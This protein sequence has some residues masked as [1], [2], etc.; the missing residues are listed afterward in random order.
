M[1]DPILVLNCGSLDAG[2]LLHLMETEKLGVDAE[3]MRAARAGEVI[4]RSWLF[5]S[6]K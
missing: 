1:S 6:V 4:S 5:P 2:V 3:R